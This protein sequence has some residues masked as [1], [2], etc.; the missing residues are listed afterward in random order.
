[1]RFLV[2]SAI[3]KNKYFCFDL[4]PLRFGAAFFCSFRKEYLSLQ[5]Y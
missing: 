1:L 4:E 2:L 3:V 5:P